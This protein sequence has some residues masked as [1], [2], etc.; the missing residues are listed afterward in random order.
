MEV[1]KQPAGSPGGSSITPSG[2][3]TDTDTMWTDGQRAR[4]VTVVETVLRS[5]SVHPLRPVGNFSASQLSF[6][7][8][9]L[10]TFSSHG[11]FL[12]MGC[13]RSVARPPVPPRAKAGRRGWGGRKSRCVRCSV[14][15]YRCAINKNV[16]ATIFSYRPV[17]N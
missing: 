17:D 9:F 12:L 16:M 4:I 13:R 6:P 1:A 2:S 8:P 7:R 5:G 15:N 14:E 3:Q 10:Y 11:V